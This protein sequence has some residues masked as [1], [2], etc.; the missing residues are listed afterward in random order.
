MPARPANAVTALLIPALALAT[1]RT[2]VSPPCLPVKPSAPAVKSSAIDPARLAGHYDLTVIATKPGRR[3]S[4]V[5]GEMVLW[6]DS[7]PQPTAPPNARPL[8]LGE[9]YPRPGLAGMTTA[10]VRKV[11]VA[12]SIDPTSQRPG[13]PGIRLLASSLRFGACPE[14]SF[15]E[16]W[17]QTDLVITQIDGQELRG[18]WRMGEL[19]LQYFRSDQADSPSGYF[20]AVRRR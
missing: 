20:C 4:M 1:T 11:G 7:T 5:V 10:E 9:V 14:G 13:Q 12:A 3:D 2:P 17:Q 19:E 8:I 15:C 18:R 16:P 6:L